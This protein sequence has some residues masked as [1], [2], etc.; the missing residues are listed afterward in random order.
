[1]PA[2]S[3]VV[4]GT[5]E[6]D[7]AEVVGAEG[8]ERDPVSHRLDEPTDIYQRDTLDERL[9]EE[10]PEAP[11][12]G[13]PAAEADQLQ[14]PEQGGDDVIAGEEEADDDEDPDELGAEEAAIHIQPE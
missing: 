10:E 5:E 13:Q 7:P 9:A 2:D 8:D 6:P 1:M 12:R 4:P 3:D 14:A 11:L